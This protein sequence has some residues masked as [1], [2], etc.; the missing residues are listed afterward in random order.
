MPWW[1]LSSTA[2]ADQEDDVEMPESA[3]PPARSDQPNAPQPLFADQDRAAA[4][5]TAIIT[6]SDASLLEAVRAAGLTT[7]DLFAARMTEHGAFLSAEKTRQEEA[8]QAEAARQEAAA[9]AQE[10]AL[11]TA[12]TQASTAAVTAFGQNSQ[13]LKDAEQT[14]AA[15]NDVSALAGIT[16]AYKAV[17]PA[18]LKPGAPRQTK[19]EKTQDDDQALDKTTKAEEQRANGLNPDKVFENRRAKS[20]RR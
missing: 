3:S 14:I 16:A 9:K 8:A 7:P 19:L 4:S 10:E 13:G 6:R 15:L 11:A 12:R 20:M 2:D 17:R 5:V 18:A 1:K